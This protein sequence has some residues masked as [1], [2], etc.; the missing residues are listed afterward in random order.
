MSTKLAFNSYT[1]R[2]KLNNPA[3]VEATLRKA[4]DLGYEAVELDLDG[5][6][7]QFEAGEL[8]DLLSRIDMKAFSAHTE[9]D[10]LELGIEDSIGNIKTLGLEYVVV[11]NLP[12]ERFCK[13]EQGWLAGTR[14]LASFAERLKKEGIKFAY[15]NHSKEFEKYRGRT[16]MEIVFNEANWK[17]YLVEIDVCWVQY[18]GGDPAQ[19]L[20][21]YSGR[22]PL[23]HIKDLGMV[24]GKPVTM[25]VGDGNMNLPYILDACRES[26][27]Q[28]YIV[29]QDDPLM[30]SID[31]LRVSKDYLEKHGVS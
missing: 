2:D 25:E 10:R 28:W 9:F 26:G 23:A 24:N 27:V 3:N 12:R 21:K 4:R 22:V 19:W 18:A 16:A 31:S 1:V 13:D 17:D 8:K 29:E 11:P 7:L 5:L 14:M 15:H 20:R 30:D 6:M